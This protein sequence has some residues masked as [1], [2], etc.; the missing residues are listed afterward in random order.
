MGD[1]NGFNSLFIEYG[2]I[3]LD[4]QLALSEFL[5]DHDMDVRIDGFQ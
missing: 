3:A 1:L 2:A 4:R 5:G